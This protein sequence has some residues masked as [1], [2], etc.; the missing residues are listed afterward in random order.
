MH[1]KQEKERHQRDK[2]EHPTE[3]AG[4]TADEQSQL[5]EEVHRVVKD[6]RRVGRFILAA[7]QR[8]EESLHRARITPLHRRNGHARNRFVKIKGHAQQPEQAAHNHHQPARSSFQVFH[9]STMKAMPA[10]RAS[11]AQAE[12]WPGT[13][14]KNKSAAATAPSRAQVVEVLVTNGKQDVGRDGEKADEIEDYEQRRTQAVQRG[15]GLG[16]HQNQPAE[17][18]DAVAQEK[19]AAQLEWVTATATSMP[20]AAQSIV[21]WIVAHTPKKNIAM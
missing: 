1:F 4:Q 2:Q 16:L 18:H 12:P 14:H 11:A 3:R 20:I 5:L 10:I 7:G 15:D 8:V 9:A 6:I 21:W 13:A 17:E 19:A